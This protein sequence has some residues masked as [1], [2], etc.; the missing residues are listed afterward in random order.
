MLRR[1][2]VVCLSACFVAACQQQAVRPSQAERPPQASADVAAADRSFEALS[3]QWLADSMRLSPVNATLAGDHRYDSE[4]DDLS[5][6]GRSQAL[7][8]AQDG[9]DRLQ[10]IDAS[11]LSRANHVDYLMLRNQ[12]RADV[13]NAQTSEAW[14]WNPLV[15]TQLAG[16]SLHLL[17]AREFAPLPERLRS[18][19][20]RMEKL[21][22]LYAQARENL[23][24]SRVPK[25][26]AEIASIQNAGILSIVDELI[27]PAAVALD[28]NDRTRLDAA[29]VGLRKAVAEQ[30]TWIDRVL[31]PGARGDFR[32][33]A[34]RFDEKL[35]FALDSP[36]PRAEIRKRA[37][38]ELARVRGEMFALS[39]SILAAH[40]GAPLP[41]PRPGESEERR[42]IAAA[43]ALAAA[44]RPGRDGVIREAEVAL[45]ET[46]AFV[47]EKNLLTLPDTTL[48]IVPLPPFQRGLTFATCDPP[49]P[50]EKHLPTFYSVS[51]IPD[52]W[53]TAQVD[54]Y[55]REYNTRSVRELT[56][57][58]AMPGHFVQMWHANRYASPLRAVL[59]SGPF[60]EGWAWYTQNVMVDVGYRADDPLFRLVHL[61]WLLRGISNAIVDQMVHVDGA[62]RDE[63]VRFLIDET[64]Q[65]EREAAGKWTRA[66]L[67][68][69]QLSTYFVG[70]EEWIALRREAQQR[71]GA[72][73]DLKRYHDA[74]LSYGAPPVKYARA[75]YLDQPI[76]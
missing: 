15:Y 68:A 50:L 51:P 53:T 36:L 17:M 24:L 22:R 74:V 45:A 14:A 76:E 38:A 43:L 7:A 28:A 60:V 48:K 4:I 11:T 75:L 46:T 57:H 12:L 54:S 41:P 67:D 31:I 73:F 20:A 25:I 55:L 30:Q 61:K 5:A 21:P 65:E 16:N 47:R 27:V 66:Q 29:I 32:V 18:A 64:F 39:R 70:A 10:R 37:D 3:A 33:G 62:S 63:V 59:W 71:E 56:I 72:Q 9:L 1:L 58:E 8:F 52:D 26:H 35:A 44:E 19:T 34:Q 69:A 13:W 49:G 23:D 2:L 6:G 40:P 42:T